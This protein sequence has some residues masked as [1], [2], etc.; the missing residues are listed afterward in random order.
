[1]SRYIARFY[2]KVVGENGHEIEACQDECEID[3][4]NE[5]EAAERAKYEFCAKH[6]LAHWSLHAD[7]LIVSEAEFP[8]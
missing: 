7:R 5:E 8:S 3:A 1:M 2:K 4:S 6:G